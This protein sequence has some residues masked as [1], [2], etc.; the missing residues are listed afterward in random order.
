MEKKQGISIG[1]QK[2]KMR[3]EIEN[4][5]RMSKMMIIT[6]DKKMKSHKIKIRII[7]RLITL[8]EIY[9]KFNVLFCGY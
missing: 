8:F 7:N 1:D 2:N 5:K 3:R 9:L 4:K 6:A